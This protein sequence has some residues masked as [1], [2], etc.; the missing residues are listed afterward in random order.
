MRNGGKIV[1]GIPLLLS[2]TS[3]TNAGMGAGKGYELI[4]HA[5]PVNSCVTIVSGGV[6]HANVGQKY[7]NRNIYLILLN[8]K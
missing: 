2:S 6:V 4:V 8:F 3:S 5:L 1:D 7:L